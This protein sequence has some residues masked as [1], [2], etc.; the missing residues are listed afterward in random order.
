MEMGV[1]LQLVFSKNLRNYQRLN[2]T[3]LHAPLSVEASAE[4]T[5]LHPTIRASNLPPD[6]NL[7]IRLPSSS[8]VG[9]LAYSVIRFA[10]V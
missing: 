10:N 5:L 1:A 6:D 7:G 9:W 4:N 2:P 8:V 3:R